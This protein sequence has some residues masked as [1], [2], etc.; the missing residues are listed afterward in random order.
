MVSSMEM[1][2]ISGCP[3]GRSVD[4][5]VRLF[6]TLDYKLKKKYFVNGIQQIRRGSSW[7]HKQRSLV[8]HGNRHH[9]KIIENHSLE[10]TRGG[11]RS[12]ALKPMML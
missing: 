2:E 5:G 8:A 4:R 1:W 12:S 10:R 6:L 3:N 7:N 9:Y 11:W